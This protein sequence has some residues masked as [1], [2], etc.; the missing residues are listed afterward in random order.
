MQNECQDTLVLFS[1]G[2]GFLFPTTLCEG[3]RDLE[4][5]FYNLLFSTCLK[6]KLKPSHLLLL[7]CFWV[8]ADCGKCSATRRSRNTEDH[9]VKF[10]VC[11]HFTLSVT[12]FDLLPRA[13]VP[14]S[15]CTSC[16]QTRPA[17]QQL[18][19]WE[20]GCLGLESTGLRVGQ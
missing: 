9:R 17:D 7:L 15:L 1:G 18:P 8:Q 4:L 13:A 11:F 16:S 6:V 3:L 19:A 14:C 10:A 2:L 20:R 12:K 5:L